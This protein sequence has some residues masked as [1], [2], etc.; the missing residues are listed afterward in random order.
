MVAMVRRAFAVDAAGNL[1]VT[2]VTELVQ[3]RVYRKIRP[4][5][6]PGEHF[7]FEASDQDVYEFALDRPALFAGRHGLRAVGLKEPA[8]TNFERREGD[9]PFERT[10]PF[11]PDMPQL[12]TC[13]ECHQAPGIYSMLSMARGFR[14]NPKSNTEIFRTFSWDV[15][16]SYTTAAKTKQFN[17]G[18]LRGKLEK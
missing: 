14:D 16:M 4:L 11:S 15:E 9:D 13:I 7:R 10:T 1:R 17:W 18:L 6:P 3:I 2:P 5:P 12:R 8:D